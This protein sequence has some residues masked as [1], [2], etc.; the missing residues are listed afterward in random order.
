VI[1][2]IGRCQCYASAKTRST[3]LNRRASIRNHGSKSSRERKRVRF[4]IV[5][6]TVYSPAQTGPG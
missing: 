6:A 1:V 5:F 4:V 2:M 3:E